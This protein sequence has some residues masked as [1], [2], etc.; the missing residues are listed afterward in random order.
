MAH[1]SPDGGWRCAGRLRRRAHGTKSWPRDDPPR[2][3]SDRLCNYGGDVVADEIGTEP[4]AVASGIRTQLVYRML[5]I[6]SSVE[7]LSRSLPLA[8]L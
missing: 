6:N 5:I 1:I 4:R 8:V 7:L 2:D 3:R